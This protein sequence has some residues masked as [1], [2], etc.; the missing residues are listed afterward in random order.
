M[1]NKGHLLIMAM[2]EKR[3]N[4]SNLT[5]NVTFTTQLTLCLSLNSSKKAHIEGFAQND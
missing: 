3:K 1:A 2:K 4:Q 5:Y